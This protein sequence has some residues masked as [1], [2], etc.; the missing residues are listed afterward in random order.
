MKTWMCAMLMTMAVGAS[1]QNQIGSDD[2]NETETELYARNRYSG[3]K[4]KIVIAVGMAIGISE[5]IYGKKEEEQEKARRSDRP[6][7]RALKKI[8]RKIVFMHCQSSDCVL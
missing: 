8:K 3:K 6:A 4:F 1:A 2:T 5:N 7:V